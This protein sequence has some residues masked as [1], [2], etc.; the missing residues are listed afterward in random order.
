MSTCLIEVYTL[1][2]DNKHCVLL[3]FISR[4]HCVEPL[5]SIFANIPHQGYQKLVPQSAVANIPHQGYRKPVPQSAVANI[6]HQGY[7]RPVLQS[8][9]VNIDHEG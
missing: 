6:H 5:Q 3:L 9:V 8:G 2:A 7:R 1:Q 4:P